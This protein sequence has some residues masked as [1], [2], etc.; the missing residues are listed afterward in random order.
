[1]E[2]QV[3]QVGVVLAPRQVDVLVV[4]ADAQHARVPLLE[5]AVALAEGGDLRR[6]DEREVLGPEEHDLPLAGLVLARDDLE[7]LALLQAHGGLQL[8]RGKT[9]SDGQH[10]LVSPLG[11]TTCVSTSDS[12]KTTYVS[13]S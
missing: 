1:R 2:R 11:G 5:V 8:E 6:T 3:L 13:M 9:V 7:L 10:L 4:G 12:S